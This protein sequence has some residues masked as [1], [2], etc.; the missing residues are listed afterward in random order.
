MENEKM[1]VPTNCFRCDGTGNLCN[2]CGESERACS[3]EDD[4]EE[5]TYFECTDCDG[6][7]RSAHA[8]VKAK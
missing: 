8:R 1:P 5:P 3:C 6:T 7:G 4:G 2:I